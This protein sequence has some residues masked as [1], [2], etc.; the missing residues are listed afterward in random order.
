M[1]QPKEFGITTFKEDLR[2]TSGAFQ[3]YSLEC[4]LVKIFLWRQSQC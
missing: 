3:E 2:K 4:P 1:K